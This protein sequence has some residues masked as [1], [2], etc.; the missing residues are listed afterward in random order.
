[1]RRYMLYL[2][3]ALVGQVPVPGAT[4][5]SMQID[6]GQP[7]DL[8]QADIFLCSRADENSTRFYSGSL[9]HLGLWDAALSAE[10]VLQ[11][12]PHLRLALCLALSGRCMR[13][14]IQPVQSC[15]AFGQFWCGLWHS[16]SHW[17][18]QAC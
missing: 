16:V 6:G 5:P 1:M 2:D 14:Q 13:M 10:E 18:H 17:K 11:L 7:V 9:T 8:G 3:G 12:T 15:C 4:D